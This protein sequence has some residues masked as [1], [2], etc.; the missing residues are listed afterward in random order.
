MLFF[1]RP[2]SFLG[3]AM[4]PIALAFAVLELTESA[5]DLGIVVACAP[6]RHCCWAASGRTGYPGI[7]CS[8]GSRRGS[9][10]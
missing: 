3:N 5:G 4:A 1:G 7:C 10:S 9:R 8:R 2:V 6:A